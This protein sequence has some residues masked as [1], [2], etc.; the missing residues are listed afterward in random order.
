M[1]TKIH[2]T[3]TS[4]KIQNHAE[5]IAKKIFSLKKKLEE[6]DTKYQCHLTPQRRAQYRTAVEKFNAEYESYA[7]MRDKAFEPDKEFDPQQ[8]ILFRFKRM[9]AALLRMHTIYDKLDRDLRGLVHDEKIMQKIMEK[10]NFKG[11]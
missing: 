1:A 11:K 8:T 4:D 10:N 6:I 2:R 7:T 9:G 5:K 3:K